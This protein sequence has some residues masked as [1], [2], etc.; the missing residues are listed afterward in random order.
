MRIIGALFFRSLRLYIECCFSNLLFSTSPSARTCVS[1]PHFEV[2]SR[3]FLFFER[4]WMC[5]WAQILIKNI[6]IIPNRRT[7]RVFVIY[8]PTKQGTVLLL[9]ACAHSACSGGEQSS[10]LLKLP[11]SLFLF[12]MA[13]L[14]P[15]TLSPF[16]LD[17]VSGDHYFDLAWALNW[18]ARVLST[19]PT[20]SLYFL[21]L[22]SNRHNTSPLNDKHTYY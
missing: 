11:L 18:P 12:G 14:F 7:N 21:S 5:K 2:E 6:K 15:H 8:I 19:F 4:G 20:R 1:P 22:A 16:L 13:F 9:H 17:R 3:H 10:C